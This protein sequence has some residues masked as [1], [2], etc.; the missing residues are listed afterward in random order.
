MF[1]A[2]VLAKSG[3]AR[4]AGTDKPT[5]LIGA[6]S[7]LERA[8]AAVASAER[9]IVVGPTRAVGREVIWCVEEPPGGGPVAAV[10]AGLPHARAEL[11]VVL[12]ADLPW[13]APAVPLLTAALAADPELDAA[14][15]V[16]RD[17]RR[18]HLAA[19]WRAD[20]LRAATA[21]VGPAA[22]AAARDL[23]RSAAL[24]DV[25]DPGGAGE[26]CDTWADVA[27]AR[28]RAELTPAEREAR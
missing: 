8:L 7:L 18:N 28:R 27:R 25:A 23:Y 11:V 24:A 3:S 15:L 12:A 9:T 22:G 10:A 1:D 26:D 4:L 20:S 13:I 6:T 16:D 17:G 19:A 14:V 5:L 2:I 21:A